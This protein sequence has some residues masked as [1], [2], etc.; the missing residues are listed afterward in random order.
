MK[1]TVR[2]FLACF[3]VFALLGLGGCG[4]GDANDQL[5]GGECATAEDCDDGDDDTPALEC[6]TV[7]KGG[8]CGRQG[9]SSNADCPE[10]SIC[11][12]HE[13]VNYCFLVCT[14]KSQ[15]NQN[16]TVENES[17]CSSNINPVE[18]GEDKVCVPPSG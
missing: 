1:P 4:E 2:A 17:N 13:T 10:K 15:C 14:T 11:V 9:C 6:I 5:I 8:Y 7:F 3:G 16:R 12:T 18:G